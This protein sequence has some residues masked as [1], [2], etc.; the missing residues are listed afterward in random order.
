MSCAEELEQTLSPGLAKLL[1]DSSRFALTKI[2]VTVFLK[3]QPPRDIAVQHEHAAVGQS[4]ADVDTPVL[5]VCGV[6][7]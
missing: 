2:L 4:V 5:N 1:Y 6:L 7:I 3:R